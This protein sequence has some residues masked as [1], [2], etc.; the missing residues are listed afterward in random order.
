MS[1]R[2]LSAHSHGI[3]LC[4]VCE[5]SPSDK[6]SEGALE[7]QSVCDL[8]YFL[9]VSRLLVSSAAARRPIGFANCNN[10]QKSF[11][12]SCC[13][14][15]DIKCFLVLRRL[16]RFIQTCACGGRPARLCTSRTGLCEFRGMAMAPICSGC[17]VCIASLSNKIFVSQG[18]GDGGPNEKTSQTS[19]RI[20]IRP[21]L[22]FGAAGTA[23]QTPPIYE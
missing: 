8:Q 15:G 5:S 6:R 22:I 16:L 18:K 19:F 14:L 4:D 12:T 9:R 1:I 2:R 7:V 17:N 13:V 20:G 23:R 3:R 21:W 11:R 10:F